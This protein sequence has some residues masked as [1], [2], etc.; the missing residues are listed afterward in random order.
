MAGD[1]SELV[2]GVGGSAENT[3]LELPSAPGI[4]VNQLVCAPLLAAVQPA[5]RGGT[6]LLKRQAL[7]DLGPEAF[8]TPETDTAA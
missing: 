7:L 3:A 2:L 8:A 1:T 6:W 4:C 5:G